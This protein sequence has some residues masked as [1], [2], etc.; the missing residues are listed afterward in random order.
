MSFTA[1]VKAYSSE[2]TK[3]LVR[4]QTRQVAQALVLIIEDYPD[5]PLSNFS[6]P[7]SVSE[8]ALSPLRFSGDS[9]SDG[10]ETAPRDRYGFV[11]APECVL[12]Y[13]RW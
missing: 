12:A 3:P 5:S 7:K 13:E 6:L 4:A 8:E 10:Q 11:L 9:C 1:S 2:R